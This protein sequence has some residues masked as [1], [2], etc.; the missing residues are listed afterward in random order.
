MTRP[1]TL[2]RTAGLLYL[3]LAAL[4]TWAELFVRGGVRVP[5]DAAATAA[6][7]VN[8]ETLLRWGLAADVLMAVVFVFLGLV[9]QRLLHHVDERAAT[10]LLVF[11]SVGAGSILL[12]LAFHLGAL[13]VATG[14]ARADGMASLLL[15]LH[16]YG[17]TLGG[18]FFGLW[19]LPMGYLAWRSPLFPK[20]MGV[21]LVIGGF[22]WVVDPV[23]AFALPAAPGLVR[24]VVSAPT[25]LAEFGLM[26]YLIIRGVRSP[27]PADT[28]A[29]SS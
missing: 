17:Y 5:G 21:L 25:W 6:N 18:V 10:A 1:T 4:G 16:G 7:I 28:P 12:N 20:P 29:Y 13:Q 23:I 15:E 11:V 27:A 22:A 14:P 9:L 19:L 2:A 24:D 3:A 8:H 26:F